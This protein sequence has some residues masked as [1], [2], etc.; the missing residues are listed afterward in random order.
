MCFFVHLWLAFTVRG[1]RVGFVSHSFP[2]LIQSLRAA[3]RGATRFALLLA[4]LFHVS[5]FA[6]MDTQEHTVI[7][8]ERAALTRWGQG[9]PDGILA[10]YAHD[11][12]YFDPFL[13]KPIE[14]SD[15]MRQYYEPVRGKRIADSFEFLNTRVQEHGD[16]ATLTFNYV[17][18]LDG[19]PNRWNATE[20]YLKTPDGWRIIQ[21]HW[22]MTEVALKVAKD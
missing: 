14:G 5:T 22:S 18:Q 15:A 4:S 8:L 12:I 10:L 6:N 3:C 19:K 9:D 11:I 2:I 21:S 20:V 13:P 16:I 7:Q 17:S 1:H